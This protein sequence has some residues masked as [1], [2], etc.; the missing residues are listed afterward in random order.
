MGYDPYDKLFRIGLKHPGRINEINSWLTGSGDLI[1]SSEPEFKYEAC[2]LSEI[3][4]RRVIRFHFADIVFLVQPYK[5]LVNEQ[6]TTS[7]TVY[8]AGTVDSLPLMRITGVARHS[9]LSTTSLYA[10]WILTNMSYWIPGCK[11]HIRVISLK[12]VRW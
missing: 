3:E 1:L 5:Y 4:Y 12:T 11:M 8:N 2:V 6:A 9:C 7:L 10:L